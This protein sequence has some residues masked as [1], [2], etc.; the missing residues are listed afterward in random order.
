MVSGEPCEAPCW[1]G[2]TGETTW[3]DALT[4]LEDDTTIENLNTQTDDNSNAALAEWNQKGGSACCQMFSDDGE[5]VSVLLLHVA[6]T[7][8]L[9][10]VI[11]RYGEPTYVVGSPFT[12]DQAALNI[13]YPDRDMVIYVFSAGATGAISETSEVFATLYVV[14]SQM[15]LLINTTSLHASEGYGS[16]EQYSE[17]NEDFEVT[18][19]ITLTP[20]ATGG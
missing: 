18:P 5:T 11:E 12:D 20:T 16:F 2:I 7:M 10:D 14:P 19:A 17:T 8:T 9:G 15:E 1:R 6:P 13:I 4:I 3:S